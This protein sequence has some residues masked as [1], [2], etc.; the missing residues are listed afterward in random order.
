[1]YTSQPVTLR[2]ESVQLKRRGQVGSNP[3][4]YSG[5]PAFK[6]LPRDYPEA[7]AAFLSPSKCRDSTSN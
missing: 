2:Y 6:S 4:S 7:F 5:G 3:P 1:M